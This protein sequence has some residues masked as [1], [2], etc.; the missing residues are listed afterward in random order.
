MADGITEDSFLDN[1][2]TLLAAT[3]LEAVDRDSG[4][5]YANPFGKLCPRC[6]SSDVEPHLTGLMEIISYDCH[7]CNAYFTAS[8]VLTSG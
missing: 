2:G 5:V 1:V 8:G 4:L 6:G 7:Q 3:N